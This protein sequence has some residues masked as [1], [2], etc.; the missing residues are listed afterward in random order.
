[1]AKKKYSFIP[2]KVY[3]SLRWLISIVL[4]AIAAL[5]SGLNQAWNWQLPMDAIL[6]TF[7]V[8]ETFLGAV[9]LGSKIVT[10]KKS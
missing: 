2:E 5:I 6:T 3:E 8:I 9:F 4:P 10:D 1:M 7:S